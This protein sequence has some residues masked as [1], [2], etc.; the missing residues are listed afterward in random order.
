MRF[1]KGSVSLSDDGGAGGNDGGGCGDC[2]K[3]GVGVSQTQTVPC[4]V[5]V[6]SVPSSGVGV[7][8][9]PSPRGG[10]SARVG[11]EQVA[12][13]LDG[14]VLGGGAEGDGHKGEEEND[15]IELRF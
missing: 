9:V 7:G 2:G 1:A 13:L 3:S 8:T 4:T 11:S 12:F 14:F 15:L 6:G 5:Q 10:D